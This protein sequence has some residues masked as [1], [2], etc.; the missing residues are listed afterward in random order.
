MKRS[1]PFFIQFVTESLTGWL[2]RWPKVL[3][4]LW[5]LSFMPKMRSSKERHLSM[6]LPIANTKWRAQLKINSQ[7]CC[8]FSLFVIRNKH[9]SHCFS[10]ERRDLIVLV[11]KQPC[12]TYNLTISSLTVAAHWLIGRPDQTPHNPSKK[13]QRGWAA[14]WEQISLNW[15][16]ISG[17]ASQPPKSALTGCQHLTTTPT[18]T[19]H[20]SIQA[21]VCPGAGHVCTS[22]VSLWQLEANKRWKPEQAILTV[23]RKYGRCREQRRLRGLDPSP[24]THSLRHITHS[25]KGLF[26]SSKHSGWKTPEWGGSVMGKRNRAH[27]TGSFEQ[28]IGFCGFTSLQFTHVLSYLKHSIA[29]IFNGSFTSDVELCEWSLWAETVSSYWIWPKNMWTVSMFASKQPSEY[30]I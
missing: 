22:A 14:V 28:R 13:L 17:T 11:R 24:S 26:S 7:K 25:L 2:E 1:L 8:Y 3:A 16:L 12:G 4:L 27:S 10:S 29:I 18:P 5:D 23:N 21:A 30:K 19:E 15:S 6:W 9:A 20:P